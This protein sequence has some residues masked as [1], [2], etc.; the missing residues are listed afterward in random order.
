M[1]FGL[2]GD[3]KTGKTTLALSFP[4]PMLYQE[5]DIGGFERAKSKFLP[6]INSGQ[7]IVK[8]YIMPLQFGNLDVAKLQITPSK[9]VVGMRELYYQILADYVIA[10]RDPNIKTIVVDTG[11]LLWEITTDAYLQEKQEAQPDKLRAQLT[12]LEYKEPNIRMRGFVYNAKA[13]DKHLVLTHHSREEYANAMVN[14]QSTKA[15]TGRK[16]RS[17]WKSLGDGADM[18]VHT[19]LKGAGKDAKYYCQVDL[20]FTQAMAGFE[21]LDPT[22]EKLSK[23]EKMMRGES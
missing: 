10:L 15:P 19:Y 16:E 8:K 6:E 22:Y 2:W 4:K 12:E 17:G 3:D 23:M 1:I 5:I 14:G 20:T 9:K 11:T 13:M 21:M 18:I 7:V